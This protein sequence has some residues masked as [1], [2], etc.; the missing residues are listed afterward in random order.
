MILTGTVTDKQT[1]E[2]LPGVSVFE[3]DSNGRPVGAG[4]ATNS[5][6]DFSIEVSPGNSITASFVG[7]QK[8]ILNSIPSSGKHDFR[9][10][11]KNLLPEATVTANRSYTGI[12]VLS[13]LVLYLF[14]DSKN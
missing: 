3:S 12:L 6:G 4:T 14:A 8:E 1:G 2:L 7:Y 9:L 5:G 10:I 11:S 13:A